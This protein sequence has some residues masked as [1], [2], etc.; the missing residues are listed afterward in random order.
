MEP[1]K[2]VKK[3]AKTGLL[4]FIMTFN[5]SILAQMSILDVSPH[6]INFTNNFE[7]I[8][9]VNLKNNGPDQIRIDSIIY[10]SSILYIRNN[11]FAN[12]PITLESD[13]SVSIDILIQ[14]YFNLENDDTSTVIQL[15][16]NSKDS[17]KFINVNID[18]QMFHGMDGFI[19]GTVSDSINPLTEAKVYFFFDGIYLIDSTQTNLSGF[20]EKELPSGKYFVAATKSNYYMQYGYLKDSPLEADFIYVSKDD[21]QTI[22]FILEHEVETIFSIG[23]IV[24]DIVSDETLSEA[25]VVIRKGDH[26]PTKTLATE[27]NMFRSY[28]VKTNSKGE[29][30]INNIQT[31]GN[32]YIQAFAGHYLPG[33]FNYEFNYS[34]FWQD[35][36]SIDIYGNESNKNIYL[37]RDSSYGAGTAKGFVRQ[38]N[39]Q[40]DS[41]NYALIFAVGNS[42]KKIYNYSFSQSSRSFE[43]PSL[44]SGDYYLQTDLVDFESSTSSV[45]TI[46]TTQDTVQNIELI[47]L[48]TSVEKITT[49]P[50][51]FSLSQNYPNPFNPTT[52]I[53]FLIVKPSN[54]VLSIYNLLGQKV[55]MLINDHYESGLYKI[56]FDASKLSSGIYIYQLQSGSKSITKKMEL[57]K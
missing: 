19:N 42:N 17:V 43:L 41:L 32:Y 37:E 49:I 35:A 6:Q 21:P 24:C 15:C 55:S 11:N 29:Y 20:F 48:P 34:G 14:N 23:G 31:A 50:N 28:S 10:N 12:F 4:F 30:K 45:F 47:L 33:Y 13:S 16:N 56:N 7:K 9:T 40:S 3:I 36:D 8:E 51:D 25:I 1:I 26:T 2:N 57:L 46:D 53:E 27:E 38:N 54:V 5:A 52:T 39:N 22:N 44:P 18:F